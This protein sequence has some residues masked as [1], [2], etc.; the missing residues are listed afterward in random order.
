MIGV[1]NRGPGVSVYRCRD[2]YAKIALSEKT[3][4]VRLDTRAANLT[5]KEFA[6]L[7]APAANTADEVYAEIKDFLP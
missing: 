4:H 7:E 6:V 1:R 5:V 3:L 2:D